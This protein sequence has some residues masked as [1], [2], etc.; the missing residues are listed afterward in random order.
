MILEPIKWHFVWYYFATID[1]IPVL[2][3]KRWKSYWP[4]IIHD[5][6]FQPWKICL[7]MICWYF[8]CEGKLR[9]IWSLWNSKFYNESGSTSLG[10]A[11]TFKPDMSLHKIYKPDH[12]IGKEKELQLH[13]YMKIVFSNLV[14]KN[15]NTKKTGRDTCIYWMYSLTKPNQS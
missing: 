6:N 12:I 13:L 8:R 15:C 14:H 3:T 11:V 7:T 9:F 2:T 1:T 10:K 5:K 4:V